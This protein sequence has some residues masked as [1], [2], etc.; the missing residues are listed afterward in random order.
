MMVLSDSSEQRGSGDGDL[1]TAI[2]DTVHAA[3][4]HL[5]LIVGFTELLGTQTNLTDEARQWLDEIVGQAETT[6]RLLVALR[7][8]AIVD[9][10][11]VHPGGGGAAA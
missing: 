7:Q 4:N 5:A 9:P 8:S 1:A 3:A 10:V 11:A 6:M 2:Q